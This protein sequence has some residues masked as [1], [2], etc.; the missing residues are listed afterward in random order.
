MSHHHPYDQTPLH[1][2]WCRPQS[3]P[4]KVPIYFE[5]DNTEEEDPFLPP[6]LSDLEHPVYLAPRYYLKI[7]YPENHLKPNTKAPSIY[8]IPHSGFLRGCVRLLLPPSVSISGNS[9]YMVEY[10]Q[11]NKVL[12]PPGYNDSN[13]PKSRVTSKDLPSNTHKYLKTEYW[14]IKPNVQ[15]SSLCMRR[16]DSDPAFPNCDFLHQ[17]KDILD[18]V[19]LT[20]ENGVTWFDYSLVNL[21]Y[22]PYIET[23][24]RE[25]VTHQVGIC[26]GQSLPRPNTKY[27]IEFHVPLSY[28]DILYFP[29]QDVR[30]RDSLSMHEG[31]YN[32]YPYQPFPSHPPHSHW[33]I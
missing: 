32:L 13:I 20:D 18:I 19:D 29:E 33:H 26:W 22:H 23:I 11:W 12:Y 16:V 31:Y 1:Q 27:K 9:S 5:I 6:K 21:S 7:F 8:R 24:T 30:S 25:E 28:K 4:A 3:T 15:K 14:N 2:H 17:R 10:W